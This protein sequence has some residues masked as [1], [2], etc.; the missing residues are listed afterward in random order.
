MIASVAGWA[1][2]LVRRVTSRLRRPYVAQRVEELP[3]ILTGRVVYIVGEGGHDWSA[4]MLC[5]CGC[6]AALEMNLVPPSRPLWRATVHEDGSA[7]L[8]PS[9]WRKIGCRSHFVLSRGR[10]QW[11]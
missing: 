5:P 6:G 3:G 11:C 10:V 8:H 9:V 1:R 4:A 2:R 7:S